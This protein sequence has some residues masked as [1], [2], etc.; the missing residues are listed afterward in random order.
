[1]EMLYALLAFMLFI[2]AM[3]VLAVNERRARDSIREEK[4]MAAMDRLF[5]RKEAT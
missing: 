5:N 2:T 4:C 1:M 3:V